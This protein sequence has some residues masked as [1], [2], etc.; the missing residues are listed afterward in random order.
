MTIDAK[1]LEEIRARLAAATE[2]PWDYYRD[3]GSYVY[4]S[5]HGRG[6]IANLND[7]WCWN[8]NAQNDAAL[9][10][11]APADL[12]ALV[13][14]VERLRVALAVAEEDEQRIDRLSHAW[15]EWPVDAIKA[16]GLDPNVTS[17]RDAVDRMEA[18]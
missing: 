7:P 8:D 15:D 10:A 3:G 14:E 16:L 17:F 13:A 4:A 12:A 18:T 9:I 6:K 5:G 1:R 11:S 2:A